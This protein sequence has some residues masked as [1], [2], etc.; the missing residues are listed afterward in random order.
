MLAIL[1]ALTFYFYGYVS[2]QIFMYR[3]WDKFGYSLATKHPIFTTPVFF[4]GV[5]AGV[6]CT[7]IQQGD[8]D[9]F[10]SMFITVIHPESQR[11]VRYFGGFLYPHFTWASYHPRAD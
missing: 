4:M 3:E 2:I 5:L 8:F 7:R 9:A 10:Q 11:G 1:M 6:L